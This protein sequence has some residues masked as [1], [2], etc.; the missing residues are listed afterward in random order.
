MEVITTHVNADF[1]AMG[2][3]IAAKQ[4]YPDALLVFPG[5]QERT[6]REFF[7]KSTVYLYDFKRLRDLDLNE[8][9]RLILVDTRQLSRIGRFA[10]VVGRREVDVHIYDH[11]PSA[12]DDIR[13]QVMVVKPFGSTVT[14]LTQLLREREIRLTPEEATL[15]SLGIFED[16]GSF[17]FSSTTPEDFEAAAYLVRCGADLN[18]V[19]D[20]VTQELTAEQVNILNELIHSAKSYS[21]QGFD[22]CIATVALDRY[23]G[24]FAVLVHKLRDIEN[25]DIIFG[26]AL[27]DDRI[28]LVARSRLPEVDVGAVA[29]FFGGGGHANAASATIRE[30]TLIQAEGKLIEVLKS[31]IHPFPTAAHLMTSPVV[32][33]RSETTMADAMQVMI[34]YNINAMPA[35]EDG[36]IVGLV[37]RQV[38][39][40]AMY[41]G[42]EKQPVREFMN[43]DFAVVGSEATL[44]DIQTHLVERHQRI[45]PVM[46]GGKITG[47]ITRRD[48]LDFLV[49]DHSNTPR[50]LYDENGQA[51]WPKRKNMV[52]VLMEQVPKEV[53]LILREFGQLAD[54]LHYRAY[55]V[56][57][58]VRDLLLRRPN[59]DIDIVVEGDGTEFARAFAVEHDVRVRCHK[60]F[61]TALIIFPDGLRIDVATAR[62]EYYQ[63]PAALPTVEFSSLKMDLF[64]RD[65]TVNTLALGLNHDEFGQ[66]ID[67]FG[68]QRDLK[69]KNIRVLHNLSFVED[70]TR[71]LRAIR[72]E[73]RFGF[74][75]SNQTAMLIRN[76]VRMGLIQKLGGRRLFHEIQLIL[77]EENPIPALRRIAEFKVLPALS[78]VMRFD[79]KMEELFNRL[80]E[81]VSWYRLSFLD[82]PLDRWWVFL[83]GLLSGLSQS[84]LEQVCQRLQF[85]PTQS[86]RLPWL[87]EKT[88]E[89]L[90]FFFQEPDVR[91]SEI[92]RALQP[93]EPEE[94]LFVMGRAQNEDVRRAVSHYFHRY[95]R[96]ETEVKGRDLKSLG[97]PPGPV[98]RKLL[99]ELLDARL[100][101]IVKDRQEEFTYLKTRYP[102]LFRRLEDGL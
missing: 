29:G 50:A 38:L 72:F 23:V 54:R 94:L 99:D 1:D 74:R 81:V 101:G 43:T 48:L 61:N 36:K 71:I 45:L 13:G 66:L 7:V 16:T 33:T 65:F 19:A 100:N 8:I 51:H 18:T 49:S 56:G 102:D 28:Y 34:R 27:M 91:P 4:L 63:Y 86:E 52:S 44:V 88:S 89:L 93:F 95:R 73:Q 53:I 21:I 79:A 17:T 46:Q 41:H 6:L 70:P 30:M 39:E 83:L 60:K 14:I 68:G 31:T 85:G 9:D 78:D 55:A 22:I 25:L 80:R 98:Y 96:V 32:F 15:M 24:D 64:R 57:G 35:V 76:A 3:M 82:E 77:N 37:N 69:E 90:R 40:K 59:L 11:H 10:E 2:S 97:L 26:L 12:P 67:F 47:V 62:F 87:Y 92:Y 75:I 42:L 84:D 5:S 58:F 20:M